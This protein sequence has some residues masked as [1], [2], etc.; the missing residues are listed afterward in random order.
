[1]DRT[2]LEQRGTNCTLQYMAQRN[3]AICMTVLLGD[4][5]HA[6]SFFPVGYAL[7]QVFRRV[8]C[9]L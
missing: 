2:L 6:F 5:P 4:F 3:F 9:G 8:T 7:A 1:M